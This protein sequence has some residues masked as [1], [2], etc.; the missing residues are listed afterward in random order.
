MRI[1]VISDTHLASL[2]PGFVRRVEELAEEVDHFFHLGD[3]VA[4]EVLDFLNSFPLTAVAGNMDYPEI[5]SHWP[6][7]VTVTLDGY[8]FGLAHGW[9]GPYGLEGRVLKEMPGMD[10]I[11]FGHT[12]RPFNEQRGR[13]LLFNPGSARRDSRSGSMYG[14]LTTGPDG[15]SGTHHLF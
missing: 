5:R 4:R 9:G 1:A 3:A 15:I 10:C 12:H 6:V 11:C 7:K 2:E 14:L 8:R 13:T